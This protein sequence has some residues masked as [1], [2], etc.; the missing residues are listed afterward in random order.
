[1]AETEAVLRAKGLAPRHQAGRLLAE[2][3]EGVAIAFE[4]A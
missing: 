3:I 2:T 1:M 4:Q